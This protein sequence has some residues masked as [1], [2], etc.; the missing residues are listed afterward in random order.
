MYN[1]FL[2]WKSPVFEFFFKNFYFDLFA[3]NKIEEM[4]IALASKRKQINL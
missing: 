3:N 4:F 2:I 1:Y